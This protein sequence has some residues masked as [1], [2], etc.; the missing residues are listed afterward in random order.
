MRKRSDTH[1]TVDFYRNLHEKF[2]STIHVS[3]KIRVKTV[4]K[5][6]STKKIKSYLQ[7]IGKYTNELNISKEDFEEILVEAK[8]LVQNNKEFYTNLYRKYKIIPLYAAICYLIP[9]MR[10]R[11]VLEEFNHQEDHTFKGIY[12]QGNLNIRPKLTVE[13]RIKRQYALYKQ[14]EDISNILEPCKGFVINAI[15]NKNCKV[16]HIK[17]NPNKDIHDTKA[18]RAIRARSKINK[19][20][21]FDFF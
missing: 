18:H 5:A 12:F 8:L 7:I 15:K 1:K 4:T 2:P 3:N 11:S 21:F 9:S 17:L 10:L 20:L 13:L 19:R 14:Q 16:S 6:S